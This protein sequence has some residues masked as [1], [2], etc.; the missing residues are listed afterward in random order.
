MRA[1]VNVMGWDGM[2]GMCGCD[3]DIGVRN[4]MRAH[5]NVMPWDGWDGWGG[6]W[7]DV[8]IDE[9]YM[10]GGVGFVYDIA[11]II[12]REL[13]RGAGEKFNMNDRGYVWEKCYICMEGEG[14][15]VGRGPGFRE[16][17]DVMWRYRRVARLQGNDMTAAVVTV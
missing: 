7:A 2:V 4:P 9:W 10:I 11:R 6:G 13:C 17:P 3:S 1:H 8:K 16:W 12:L 15:S 5:A 14:F